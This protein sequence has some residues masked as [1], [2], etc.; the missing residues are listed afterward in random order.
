MFHP[1]TY[2]CPCWEGMPAAWEARPA[3]SQPMARKDADPQPALALFLHSRFDLISVKMRRDIGCNS[4]FKNAEM[5][6]NGYSMTERILFSIGSQVSLCRKPRIWARCM[7][8]KK[9]P[10][11]ER[12]CIMH[13]HVS[14]FLHA[15]V[16]SNDWIIFPPF[17]GFDFFLHW[18]QFYKLSQCFKLF[19]GLWTCFL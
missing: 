9:C 10:A 8:V 14:S 15:I 18:F 12:I 11:E 17:F 1:F 19:L 4:P 7:E 5:E 16:L 3:G 13:P 6:V 2:S